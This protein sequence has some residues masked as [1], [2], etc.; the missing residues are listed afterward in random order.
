MPESTTYVERLVKGSAIVFV[1]FIAAGI[2]GL[3]LRMFLMR[4]LLAEDIA[5]G[6][7][8]G[9]H[10]G[11]FYIV[12][13]I[14]SFF[15]LFRGLGFDT[16]L[17]KHMP[18]FVVKKRFG[19]IKSSIDFVLLLRAAL[20]T[21]I[22]V[23]IFI[24]SYPLAQGIVGDI[25]LPSETAV[26]LIQILAIWFIMMSFFTLLKTFQ[27]FQNMP[28]FASIKF[29][30]NLS[31][32]LLALLFVGG[33]GLSVA[34]VAYAYLFTALATAMLSFAVLRRK[35]PQVF[36]AKA[37]I[38][39]P[40]VKKLSKFA[41]PIFLTGFIGL[42]IGYMDTIM[43]AAF[44]TPAEVGYYH[45]AQPL[46]T[47]LASISGTVIIVFFP[48]VSELWAK[49]ERK[50]LGNMVHFLTKF[51]FILITPAV[52]GFIAFPDIIIRMFGGEAYLAGAIVLQILGV[53]AIL[54]LLTTI[55]N[56]TL[57]G[58]GKPILVTIVTA[59]MAVFNLVANLLLIPPYGIAGAATATLG[60]YLLGSILLF[61]YAK[62]HVKL[63]LPASPLL[64]TAIGAVLTLLL[65]F[66]LKSILVLHPLPEAFVVG[67]PGLLFY[68]WWI[69]AT[70][71]VTK[72]ELRLVARIIPM[73]KW[74]LKV[75]SKIIKD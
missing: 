68:G 15:E 63:T 36:K 14:I 45:A 50:L 27:G 60:A 1:A 3:L 69:L 9:T 39:K 31:V 8:G 20:G 52:L 43:I 58:I 7:E 24:F 49:R 6:V 55:L 28:A 11:L 21:L 32:F 33:L 34:G 16:A 19:K 40:L 26:L 18:E 59:S 74:L 29:F 73:P 46:G 51:S 22:A 65:I 4:T 67:I 64:K 75:A 61:Y 71:A 17:I 38:T 53:V 42:V 70:K 54:W 47:F 72:D 62:K 56:Q 10:Y 12:F 44:R 5:F 57:V 37:S 48:M 25:G 30:D 41:L 35:Y 23:V 13:T 2:V 66:D